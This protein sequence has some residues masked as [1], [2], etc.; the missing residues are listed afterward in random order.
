ME[1]LATMMLRSLPD[2]LAPDQSEIRELLQ[3]TGASLAHC[4]LPPNQTT[5]AVTHRTVEEV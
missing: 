5:K 2:H 3:V 1:R 4:T